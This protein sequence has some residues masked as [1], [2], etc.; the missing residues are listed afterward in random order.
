MDSERCSKILADGFYL[1]LGLAKKGGHPFS[2][3]KRKIISKEN[4]LQLSR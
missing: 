3:K 4:N 2:W 1:I